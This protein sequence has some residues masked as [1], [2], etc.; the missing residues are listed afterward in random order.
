MDAVEG[1]PMPTIIQTYLKEYREAINQGKNNFK[2][3][4][5]LYPSCGFSVKEM[6]A[7]YQKKAAAA[8]F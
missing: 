4:N 5:E 7:K 6:L 3:C 8:K 1:L 2:P